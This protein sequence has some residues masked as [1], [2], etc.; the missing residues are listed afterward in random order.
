MFP[1]IT[2]LIKYLTGATIAL[3]IQTFGFFV[4]LAFWLSYAAFKKEFIR[5]EKQNLIHPFYKKNTT[6]SRAA[7]VI[8]MAYTLIGFVLGYKIIFCLLQYKLFVLFP[9]NYLFSWDGSLTGGLITGIVCFLWIYFLK[10][11]SQLF[12]LIDS[13]Q[14]I[15]P[16]EYTDKLLLW[17]AVIGF[18][19]AILFAKLEYLHE[20]FET[21]LKFLG[22]YNGLTFYGG[23]IFGAGIY[24][25]LTKKK[26][27]I[28][29][30]IAADIGSPG[31]ML[32]YAV[33]RI[34]CHLSGDG[35]WGIVN[36]APL[37]G[38][39]A[40]LPDWTWSFDYPHNVIHQGKYIEG[41]A[42]SYCNVLTQP[43][44]PTSLYESVICLSLFAALWL[45]RNKIKKPG[46]MFFI[47]I[48]SNGIER[49][50][51]EFIKTNPLY[52]IQKICLTQAQFIALLF[53]LLGISGLTWLKM[54]K[55]I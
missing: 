48:L 54:K 22:E 9:A 44:F 13:S 29:F 52:C 49:F 2:S 45:T 43:V 16:F 10:K 20:L 11:R 3:P 24:L 50:F 55:D 53:C 27:G 8:L 15:H 34:G 36:T 33:G 26:M 35:D 42:D 5:K 18:I 17:C 40:V 46:G 38:W 7:L 37:P 23:L 32:A 28:P 6:G 31:M 1:T 4:A 14:L 30:L 41:C 19:G 12:P 51:I 39:L 21:P 47:F 25:Y